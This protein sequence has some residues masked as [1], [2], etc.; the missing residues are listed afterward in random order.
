MKTQPRSNQ[1]WL[2][3]D[4]MISTEATKAHNRKMNAEERDRLENEALNSPPVI[5][6]W[7][8]KKLKELC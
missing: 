8:L 3:A 6:D 5:K 7:C 1:N 4:L 2:I